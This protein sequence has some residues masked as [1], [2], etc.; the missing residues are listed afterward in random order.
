[1]VTL[2]DAPDSHRSADRSALVDPSVSAA[3]SQIMSQLLAVQSYVAGAR[4]IVNQDHGPLCD[5]DRVHVGVLLRDVEAQIDEV[6]HR[7]DIEVG[8][9]LPA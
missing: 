5:T 9:R 8:M 3:L 4:G 2:N 6:H 1:M 7:L